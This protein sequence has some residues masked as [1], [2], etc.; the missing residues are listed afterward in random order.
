MLVC[1][2]CFKLFQTIFNNSKADIAMTPS[3]V[4][5]LDTTVL[6]ESC[7]NPFGQSS[8]DVTVRAWHHAQSLAK[9]CDIMLRPPGEEGEE[10]YSTVVAKSFR[11]PRSFRTQRCILV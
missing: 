1:V 3:I 6:G 9:V 11:T 10:V 5:P 7:K 8:S 4:P 2:S